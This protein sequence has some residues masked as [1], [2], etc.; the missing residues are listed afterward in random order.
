MDRL[1]A[2]LGAL[3]TKLSRAML[4]EDADSHLISR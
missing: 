1:V 2:E 3:L 4:G